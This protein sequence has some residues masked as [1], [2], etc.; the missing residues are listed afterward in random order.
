MQIEVAQSTIPKIRIEATT[1][2][3]NRN[4]ISN[5]PVDQI[6]GSKEKGVMTKR[7][8]NEELCLISQVEPKIIDEVVK[9]DYW[10][11]EMKEELDQILK[12]DTWKLV[13]NLR[14]RM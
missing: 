11:K 14:R 7:K 1:P 12:N 10:M 5:H 13:P 3:T 8:I 2:T 6:I 9:D 4:M